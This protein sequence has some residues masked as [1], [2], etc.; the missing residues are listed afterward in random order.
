MVCVSRRSLRGGSELTYIYDAHLRSGA[1]NVTREEA[2]LLPPRR[3]PTRAAT[4]A[5]PPFPLIVSSRNKTHPPFVLGPPVWPH[6]Q[7]RASIDTAR[8]PGNDGGQ[9]SCR[10]KRSLLYPP[11]SACPSTPTPLD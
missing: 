10:D 5:G 8:A 3:D 4:P 2:T 7:P 6:T 9:E 1:Y 11:P